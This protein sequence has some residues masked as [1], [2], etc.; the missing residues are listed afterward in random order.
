MRLPE[1]ALE[2]PISYLIGILQKLPPGTTYHEDE[3]SFWG[4]ETP[5]HNLGTGYTLHINIVEGFNPPREVGR[6]EW[7]EAMNA[8]AIMDEEGRVEE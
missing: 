4:G 8:P 3:P 6:E 7:E 2:K 1:N 5:D